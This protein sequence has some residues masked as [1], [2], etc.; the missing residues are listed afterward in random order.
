[1]WQTLFIIWPIC[2]CLCKVVEK[3][4]CL[5]V[6]QG[7]YHV[8]EIVTCFLCYLCLRV[9]KEI[10]KPQILLKTQEGVASPSVQS[11]CENLLVIT[12][13]RGALY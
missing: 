11:L 2:I 3:S 4:F 8:A 9:R 7:I 5:Q 1:M 10:N 13:E 12:E 6:T